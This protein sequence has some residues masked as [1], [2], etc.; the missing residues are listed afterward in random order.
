MSPG[1]LALMCDEQDTMFM[2]A[3]SP[4]A[5][6]GLGSRMAPRLPNSG[7]PSELYAEQERRVL[8]E[9]RDCLQKLITVG[10]MRGKPSKF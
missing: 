8:T 10:R 3:A 2:A 6:P 5:V 4:S 1:T 7:R 9:F